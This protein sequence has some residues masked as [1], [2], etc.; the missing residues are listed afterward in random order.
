MNHVAA[1]E[2]GGGYVRKMSPAKGAA[3]VELDLRDTCSKDRKL[4]TRGAAGGFSILDR[5]SLW[6]FLDSFG[7]SRAL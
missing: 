4:S 5:P 6:I 7:T 2:K 3:A 1:R